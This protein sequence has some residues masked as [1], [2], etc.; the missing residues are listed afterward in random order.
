MIELLVVI[1]IIAILAAMLLPALA[2]SKS[3]AQ[4]ARCMNNNKQLLVGWYMYSDDNTDKVL[5]DTAWMQGDFSS[6]SYLDVEPEWFLDKSPL[7]PYVGK[8]RD[9][10]HC[11]S[12]P[13]RGV[14]RTGAS[15]PRIRSVSMSQVFGAGAWLPSSRY[16]TYAKFST[17]SRPAETFVFIEEHPNSINDS[18]FAVQMYL[19]S[20]DGTPM[21]VDF[22]ASFHNGACGMSFAD[23]HA[24]IHKW[25]GKAIQPPVD[26][27]KRSR[28]I[29]AAASAGDSGEDIRW[30][31]QRTTARK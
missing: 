21:I 14:D 10:F 28:A 7:M 6:P 20:A 17:I 26:P 19:D 30:L 2:K 8:N 3:K 31:S 27:T 15:R 1:A 25:K 22:P 12:D 11:P 24:E 4:A 13:I 29:P 18:A 9:I 23:G 5:G 16:A